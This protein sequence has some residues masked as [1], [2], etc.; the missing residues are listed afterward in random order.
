MSITRR[1]RKPLVLLALALFVVAVAGA[2][3]GAWVTRRNRERDETLRSRY[4][5]IAISRGITIVDQPLLVLRGHSRPVNQVAFSPA[6]NRIASAGGDGDATVKLWDS[7]MGELL[8]TFSGHERGVYN[9]AF[10]RD[11]E[12]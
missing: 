12:R 11:G 8:R 6:G 2:A 3:W 9:L 5:R 4:E 1:Y 10:S 7:Q